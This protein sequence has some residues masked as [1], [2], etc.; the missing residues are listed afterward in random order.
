MAKKKQ[1]PAAP[2]HYLAIAAFCTKVLEDVNGLMSGIRFFDHI[3]AHVPA[4]RDPETREPISLW[5]LIGFRSSS[6]AGDHLLRLVMRT[7]TGERRA[8]GEYPMTL[9][10]HVTSINYR[11]KVDLRIKTQGLW[12]M[13]VIFDGKRYTSMPLWVSFAPSREAYDRSTGTPT[14]R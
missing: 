8:V 4:D 7:P 5:A 9:A 3:T 14:G 11:I 1:A 6:L 2:K 10:T 12:W 13:D